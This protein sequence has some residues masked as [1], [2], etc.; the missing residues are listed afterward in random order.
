MPKHY[1]NKAVSQMRIDADLFAK[2]KA[3]AAA[4][5]RTMNKQL[6]FFIT[7]GV[8]QYEAQHGPVPVPDE[9]EQE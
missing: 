2:L 3:I 7:Q 8:R 1:P 6:E 9:A 4:E 5:R